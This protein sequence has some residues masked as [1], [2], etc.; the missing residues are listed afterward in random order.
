MK[1][2]KQIPMDVIFDI[3]TSLPV[4]S[5]VRFRC[6]SK[7]CSSIITSQ[8]FAKMHAILF[9]RIK[10]EVPLIPT[11]IISCSTELQSAQMFFSAELL[12]GSLSASAVHLR[13]I[14]PRFSRYTTPSVNGLICM[15]FGLCATIFNPS[16]RE[17]F[18]LPFVCPPNSPAAASTSFCVNSF[19]FDPITDC[20]K[21]LNSWA[22]SGKGTEYRVLTL[23]T[24]NHWRL[25]GDGPSFFPKRESVC[26]H[27]IIYFKCHYA[28]VLF[29]FDVHTEKF[30]E[31]PLP[32]GV[33]NWRSDL[34]Q[35]GGRLALVDTQFD[36]PSNSMNIWLLEDH[37]MN[38][39]IGHTIVYPASWKEIE[40]YQN[41]LIVGTI[42]TGEILLAPRTL[43]K[44][45]CVYIYDVERRRLRRIALS[46]LPE[47][48]PLDYSSNAVIVTNYEQNILSLA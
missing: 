29:A 25:L 33:F 9:S 41:F 48:R 12:E 17:A 35:F 16:T 10:S 39:W 21:V 24:N 28:S 22:V 31:I 38:E 43:L 3:F 14:P 2:R 34:I 36:S 23:E 1:S 8:D 19:G 37:L 26:I 30:H 7:S 20:Y 6:I 11:I 27:G 15:D 18:N 46:G 42:H 5:L 40:G 45:F 44:H 13:T 47:Y 32:E 4:K